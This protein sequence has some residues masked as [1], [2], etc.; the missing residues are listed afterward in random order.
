[1][2]QCLNRKKRRE[3]AVKCAFDWQLCPPSLTLRNTLYLRKFFC[4]C[5]NKDG[6]SAVFSETLALATLAEKIFQ[7]VSSSAW[8]SANVECARLHR[9]RNTSSF[10]RLSE[11]ISAQIIRHLNRLEFSVTT[12][13]TDNCIHNQNSSKLLPLVHLNVHYPDM[14][15]DLLSNIYFNL[16]LHYYIQRVNSLSRKIFLFA[17]YSEPLSMTF[18]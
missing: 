12:F 10:A 18:N 11:T 15:F 9:D 5:L 4:R 14:N 17:K 1:M 7:L 8:Q 2:C 16:L 13:V 3:K 6:Y